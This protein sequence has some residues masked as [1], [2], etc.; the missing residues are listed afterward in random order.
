MNIDFSKSTLQG[1]VNSVYQNVH[2]FFCDDDNCKDKKSKM[3]PTKT[4]TTKTTTT[5]TYT[6][7]TTTTKTTISKPKKQVIKYCCYYP[8]T[9]QGTVAYGISL[10]YRSTTCL[11]IRLEES[12]LVNKQVDKSSSFVQSVQLSAECK[13]SYVERM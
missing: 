1:P 4:T 8:H 11:F 2:V 13:H 12:S 3:A 5:K 9:F 6:I 7:Q 10:V